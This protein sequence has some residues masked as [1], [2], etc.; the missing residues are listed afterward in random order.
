MEEGHGEL[1]KRQ[2]QHS[3]RAVMVPEVYW[4]QGIRVQVER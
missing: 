4:L 3:R 2:C 1:L